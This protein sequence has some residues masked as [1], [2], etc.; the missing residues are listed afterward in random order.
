[1][2][3]MKRHHQLLVELENKIK[4]IG[5]EVGGCA[6]LRKKNKVGYEDYVLVEHPTEQRYLI[7][8]DMFYQQPLDILDEAELIYKFEQ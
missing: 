4:E 8:K 3:D 7:N 1:M 5:I 6:L 2:S